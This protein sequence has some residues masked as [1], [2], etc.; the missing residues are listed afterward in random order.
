[1]SGADSHSP[2]AARTPTFKHFFSRVPQLSGA[3]FQAFVGGTAEERK[4]NPASFLHPWHWGFPP[5]LE[6][7]DQCFKAMMV[8]RFQKNGGFLLDW[9]Q[10]RIDR[11]VC[12]ATMI[13]H[14]FHQSHVAVFAPTFRPAV[15]ELIWTVIQM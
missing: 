4:K 10:D 13:A 15:G 5:K 1:M 6:A 2:A 9:L 14:S 3:D 12:Y 11:L 8:G 7:A